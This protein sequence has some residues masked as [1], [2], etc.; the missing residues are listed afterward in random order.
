M[1]IFKGCSFVDLS[2]FIACKIFIP[3]LFG[4]HSIGGILVDLGN[5]TKKTKLPSEHFW[6]LLHIQ[7][8]TRI[9]GMEDYT[10]RVMVK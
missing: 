3:K 9:H 7:Y 10:Y 4:I 2:D 8:I 6:K 1:V 5:E